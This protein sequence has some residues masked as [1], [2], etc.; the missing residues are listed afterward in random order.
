MNPNARASINPKSRK[1]EINGNN[2][3]PS[4]RSKESMA[5]S[6]ELLQL[7]VKQKQA[8]DKGVGVDIELVS[9][10]NIDNETF[11]ERN[12]TVIFF[13]FFWKCFYLF[14]DDLKQ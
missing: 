8:G 1:W 3:A 10:I 9:A 13:F 4:K 7:S 12:F 2:T 6:Q 5:I 11:L 14:V